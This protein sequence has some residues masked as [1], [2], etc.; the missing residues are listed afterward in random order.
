MAMPSLALADKLVGKLEKTGVD[1]TPTTGLIPL[2]DE[3]DLGQKLLDLVVSAR[4]VGLEPERA[5]RSTLRNA[6]AY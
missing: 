2:K 6:T 4:A 1:L 5:L 3:A